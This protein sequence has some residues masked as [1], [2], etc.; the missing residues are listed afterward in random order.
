M[1]GLRTSWRGGATWMSTLMVGGG[2]GMEKGIVEGCGGYGGSKGHGHSRNTSPW[3]YKAIKAQS[4]RVG[5]TTGIS[6]MIS[7][8][9]CTNEFE[10]LGILKCPWGEIPGT[11]MENW[12]FW[13]SRNVNLMVEPWRWVNGNGVVGGWRVAEIGIEMNDFLTGG[14]R[15]QL[16]SRPQPVLGFW[17][18]SGDCVPLA[19]GLTGSRFVLWPFSL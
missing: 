15:M 2:M 18:T 8:K 10:G 7:K 16:T 6:K 17:A 4:Q 1:P 12:F 5:W 11:R 19:P 9:D 3:A 13:K 14:P